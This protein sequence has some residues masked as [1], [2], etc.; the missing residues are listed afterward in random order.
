MPAPIGAPTLSAASPLPTAVA[1]ADILPNLKFLSL[2]IFLLRIFP[3]VFCTGFLVPTSAKS[4][5]IP[6]I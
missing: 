4:S 1:G 3:P 2:L 6:Y 5:A